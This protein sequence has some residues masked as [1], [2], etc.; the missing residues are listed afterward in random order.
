MSEKEEWVTIDGWRGAYEVSSL[1]RVRSVS[2]L[3]SNG[4]GHRLLLERTIRQAPDQTGRLFVALYASSQRTLKPVHVL[5]AEAFH[6]ARPDGKVCRHLNGNE[7][8]NR[9]TNL[10][11]GTPSE[12]AHDQ[13][14]HGVHFQA[15]K[16]HCP[17]GHEYSEGNTIVTKSNRRRCRACNKAECRRRR[18]T[19]RD[20]DE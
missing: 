10:K 2:R 7:L 9:A 17:Q 3:V 5:V 1:G 20:A 4:T 11:W 16:T 12:N 14:A 19:R 18:E 13:V 6:G 8:D 15:R